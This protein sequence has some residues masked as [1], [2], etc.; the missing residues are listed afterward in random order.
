MPSAKCFLYFPNFFFFLLS[1][2]LVLLFS[3]V[4]FSSVMVVSNV[5]NT[6]KR[7][8]RTKIPPTRYCRP[9]WEVRPGVALDTVLLSSVVNISSS[10]C[11][12]SCSQA[13]NGYMYL[14]Y[15]VKK[16]I[17]L[18]KLCFCTISQFMVKTFDSRYVV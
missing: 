5:V 16:V 2:F 9:S 11:I 17:F 18:N 1:L 8:K 13:S 15:N 3:L 14:L 10:Y 6:Y 7:Y 4:L 12:V